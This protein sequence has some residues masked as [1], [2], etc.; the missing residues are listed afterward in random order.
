MAAATGAIVGVQTTGTLTIDATPVT[1]IF[2]DP[3]SAAVGKR[4]YCATT[5]GKLSIAAPNVDGGFIQKVG[6][7]VAIA[8]NLITVAIQVGDMTITPA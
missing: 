7:V 2:T 5:S 1:G 3:A 6:T 8:A 4:V